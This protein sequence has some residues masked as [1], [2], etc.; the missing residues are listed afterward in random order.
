MHELV[1][2]R[3]HMR[4]LILGITGALHVGLGTVADE[5]VLLAVLDVLVESCVV[6]STARLVA[7]IGHGEQR[8]QGVGAHAALH[9]AAHTVADEPGHELLLQQIIH[10]LV[11]VGAAVV[12][13]TVRVLDY[14]DIRVLGVVGGVV[15]LL[16]NIGAADDPGRQIAVSVGTVNLLAVEID[17]GLHLQQTSLVLFI[18]TD[19]H[20]D[21]TSKNFSFPARVGRG[22]AKN[23][24]G[25]RDRSSGPWRSFQ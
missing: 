2:V 17:V 23:N 21:H 16:H 14:A 18:S 24:S 12:D 15:T 10:G 9:A 20:W 19:S 13:G 5:V 25:D 3:L 7:V 22:M 4:S 6:L 1:G 8:V 11:D